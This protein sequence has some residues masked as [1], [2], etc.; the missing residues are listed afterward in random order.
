MSKV[1]LNHWFVKDNDFSISLMRY[2][3][4]ICPIAY[5]NKLSYVMNVMDDE[6][7]KTF[8]FETLEES[9]RFTEDVVNNSHNME[10]IITQ[11]ND[12]VNKPKVKR[13]K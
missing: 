8:Y 11:Y 4:I 5:N 6:N 2:Y 1:N 9:I 13:K 12:F 7:N 10:M 3:V